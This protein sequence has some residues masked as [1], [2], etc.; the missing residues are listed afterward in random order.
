MGYKARSPDSNQAGRVAAQTVRTLPDSTHFLLLKILSPQPLPP[1]LTR[2]LASL[3]AHPDETGWIRLSTDAPWEEVLRL[4]CRMPLP[5]QARVTVYR[6]IHLVDDA[7]PYR[8]LW[9]RTEELASALA[10][11]RLG[12]APWPTL[13]PGELV[14]LAPGS[15]SHGA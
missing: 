2:A 13:L 3:Q 9:D 14:R 11:W 4:T 5:P 8:R 7:G 6:E 12:E 10:A 1:E 15:A